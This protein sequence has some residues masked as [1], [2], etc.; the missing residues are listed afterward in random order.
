[1]SG[2]QSKA[3]TVNVAGWKDQFLLEL[4]GGYASGATKP[5][6]FIPSDIVG[7]AWNQAGFRSTL[8]WKRS[9]EDSYTV[10]LECF[11]LGGP[12]SSLAPSRAFEKQPD[13]IAM[14]PSMKRAADWM[15]PQLQ[16]LGLLTLMALMFSSLA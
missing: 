15:V 14:F 13:F 9:A 10:V 7:V 5:T 16:I 6:R 3:G 4:V 1:M 12:S 2:R 11:E 8:G